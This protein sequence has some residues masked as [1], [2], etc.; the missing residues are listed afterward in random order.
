MK[1]VTAL[2]R[3]A[4]ALGLYAAALAAWLL[5][6]TALALY[7]AVTLPPARA[8]APE[9]F[10]LADLAPLD[11]G[12]YAA[13]SGDPQLLLPGTVDGEPVRTVAYALTQGGQETVCA[14]YTRREGQDFSD[15]MRL[16]PDYGQ[17]QRALYV[18]PRGGVAAVRLDVTSVAGD[19]LAFDHITLNARVPL[20]RYFVPGPVGIALFLTLPGLCCLFCVFL[21][22]CLRSTD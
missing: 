18:L 6:G 11:D 4:P 21:R 14:Y 16:W 5:W 12:R 17:T 19:V 15:R 9:D 20:W 2:L 8:L 7:D 22:R 3:K 1:A 13:L 10:E